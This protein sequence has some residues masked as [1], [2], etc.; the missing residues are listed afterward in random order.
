M[1]EMDGCIAAFS[2]IHPSEVIDHFFVARPYA[3]RGVGKALMVQIHRVAQ[4]AGM[5]RLWADVSLCA[6]P[7]FSRSGFAVQA[8]QQVQVRGVVLANARMGKALI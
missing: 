3:G 6:E 4:Q 7:F 1:A 2:D 8:R 5:P